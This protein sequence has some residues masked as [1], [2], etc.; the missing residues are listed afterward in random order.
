[1]NSRER[2]FA[3]L[4]RRAPDRVP[5]M[6]LSIDWKVMKGLNFNSYFEMIDGLDLDAVSV[7]QVQYLVGIKKYLLKVKK[8][9]RDSWGVQRRIMDELLPYAVQH[10][11]QEKEALCRYRPPDPK[12]D[13]V[14]KAIRKVV[15]RFKGKRAIL[16]VGRALFVNSWSLCSMENLLVSYLDDPDFARKLGRMAVEYNK[17]LHRLAIRA[18]VDL[19]VL[20]D[21]YA[22][23]LGPIMSPKHFCEFILPGLTEIVLNI[24]K[25]GA[26]CIKH[27][28][29]NIWDLIEPIVETG[30]DGIGPLE[31]L[32]AMD[33]AR[34]KDRFGSRVCV[35][36]N[37]DVDLLC[38]GSIESVRE[39]TR[40][41]LEKVSPG[42]GHI[43]SS[44]NSIT[45]AVEPRN[46]LAM[47]E[48]AKKFGTYPL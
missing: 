12:N 21:D 31:P 33:L 14:L 22:H 18:G 28:D 3:A 47:L 48:T 29:G 38:R 7:N 23:K 37:V 11:L 6:E 9:Y 13:P 25:E 42:G 26:F 5:A 1:M 39:A 24:K 16:L 19:I 35:V 43:L 44:G 17:E 2:I 46:F 36:G 34:V 32:A 45:S 40:N 41:L 30:I 8:T 10:P 15:K 27:T 4:E 20:G